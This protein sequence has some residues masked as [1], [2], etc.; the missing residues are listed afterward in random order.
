M[1]T[2]ISKKS[3]RK[4]VATFLLLALCVIFITTNAAALPGDTAI[5]T[6]LFDNDGRPVFSEM[7]DW[8]AQIK[9]FGFDI[10]AAREIKSVTGDYFVCVSKTGTRSIGVFVYDTST[11]SMSH[12][13]WEVRDMK[14]HSVAFK[15][16][17]IIKKDYIT[18]VGNSSGTYTVAYGAGELFDPGQAG[19]F[20]LI[21]NTGRNSPLET[22]VRFALEK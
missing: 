21:V 4:C 10:V 11:H 6:P 18:V 13:G 1:N 2:T 16:T 19:P 22:K 20:D 8:I 15:P 9:T 14:G 7:N 5:M 12:I 3:S 17:G